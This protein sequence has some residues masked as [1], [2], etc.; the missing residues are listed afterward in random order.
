M[1]VYKINIEDSLAEILEKGAAMT[2]NNVESFIAQILNRFAID[3][4]IME[5]EDVKEGYREVGDINLEI[6]NH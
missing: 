1:K 2:D 3:P 5:Q 6:S 4:H